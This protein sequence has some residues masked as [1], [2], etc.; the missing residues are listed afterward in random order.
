MLHDYFQ[1][2]R[3][4]WEWNG[5]LKMENPKMEKPEM[6]NLDLRQYYWLWW[7]KREYNQSNAYTLYVLP[8]FPYLCYWLLDGLLNNM[9]K[10]VVENRWIEV[11]VCQRINQWVHDIYVIFTY[12]THRNT[13]EHMNDIERIEKCSQY[14][15][16]KLSLDT[17][18][19]HY[20]TYKLN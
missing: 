7:Q 16:T 17:Q 20:Y 14:I 8:S 18:I 5:K 1:T 13:P 10:E 19:I 12:V 3:I 4:S 11:G 6:G 2:L 9:Y 15:M